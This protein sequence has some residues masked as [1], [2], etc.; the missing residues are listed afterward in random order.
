MVAVGAVMV[1][2]AGACGDDDTGGGDGGAASSEDEVDGGAEVSGPAVRVETV[3]VEAAPGPA[4]YNQV[5]VVEHGPEDAENV[6]VLVPGT[7]AGAAYFTPVALDIVSELD[8]WQVWSVDRREN[9]LEDHS[10]LERRVAGEIT[11]QVVFDYYL[12]WLGDD[13]ITDHFEPAGGLAGDEQTVDFAREWGMRVTIDDLHAVIEEAAGLGGEVVLGGHSLGGSITVAYATWDFDGR[14][15]AA[16][17][18]GLALIDGGSG[19]GQPPSVEDAE[20]ELAELETG[21]AFN[22]IVGLGLP[23]AAGVFNSL[24]S[25]STVLE[26]DEPSLA[27]DSPLIPANLKPTMQ[28]TNAAQYGYALD[29]KT[30]PDGLELVQMHIGRLADSGD[31]RGWVDDELVPV[32]RAARMFSGLLEGA[33]G[34]M[35][36]DGIDGTAWYHPRRLS[37]D[38]GAVNGGIENPAQDVLGVRAIHGSELDLP[39]YALETSFGAG[40]VL[41]GAR[42]LAEQSGIPESELTLVGESDRLTHTDPMGVET[43][44][45]PLVE[46]LVPFLSEIG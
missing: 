45:N 24:G 2:V 35:S 31:P 17:L 15:G 18:S 38:S 23:W 30:S 14:P 6:L 34:D 39:I 21:S 44:Q 13:S 36:L 5:R 28:P 42:L 16:A 22:D 25:T 11:S 1:L 19:A 41:N 40:R 33:D 43:S 37:L 8:G 7:S 10:A 27:F 12:G 9:L 29:T 26:P 32:E 20:T 46:T 4:E 3:E